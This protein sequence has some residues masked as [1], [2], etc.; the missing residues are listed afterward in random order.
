[1]RQGIIVQARGANLDG[2]MSWGRGEVFR[3]SEHAL[4]TYGAA[5]HVLRPVEVEAH[6]KRI[7]SPL[8]Y[9]G[10]PGI[11]VEVAQD[12]PRST[13]EGPEGDPMGEI[14]EAPSASQRDL[15]GPAFDR[16]MEGKASGRR[17]RG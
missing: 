11:G 4:A 16:S 10:T 8:R 6:F 2:E 1:M 15:L 3:I 9:V 12:A 13:Q 14:H 5:L 17:R 7:P